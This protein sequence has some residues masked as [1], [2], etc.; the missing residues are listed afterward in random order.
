MQFTDYYKVLGLEK[1]ASEA[2]IKK[3][4]RTL[5]RQ[6]HP[7]ANPDKPEAEEKF[8]QISE[9]YEVLSD[10][11]KKAKYDQINSQYRAYQNGGGR[12]SWQDF[13]QQGGYQFSQEDL[14]DMFGG[15]SFGDLLSQLFGGGRGSG[16]R[17][18]GTRHSAQGARQQ[19]P[20]QQVYSITLLM[21]EAFEGVTKRL[22]LGNKKIDVTFKPGIGDG[23]RLK[24]PVGLLEVRIAPHHRYTREGDDL[25]VIEHVPVS[26]VLLGG[27]HSVQTPSGEVTM[28]IPAGTPSGRTMRLK[29]QGM[30]NYKNPQMRGDLYVTIYVDV[31]SS[32]T[33]E[34][35]ELAEQLKASGL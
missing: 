11:Q 13:S 2:E 8:K 3:A 7:D 21:E 19:A 1:G 26:T 16:R 6:Y 15:T 25:K 22:A 4:F 35:Q 12:G 29:G 32:L 34:Q 5:A 9:A 20:E 33:A 27:K 30:P 10:P 31:P 18:Q 17:T 23:Q 24:I 28:T 14:G